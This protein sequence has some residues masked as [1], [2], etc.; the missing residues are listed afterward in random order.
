MN[1]NVRL[2]DAILEEAKILLRHAGRVY[3]IRWNRHYRVV[4]S[5]RGYEHARDEALVAEFRDYDFYTDEQRAENY[6]NDRRQY[7]EWYMGKRDYDLLRRMEEGVD[8]DPKTGTL[9]VPVGRIVDGDFV[10]TGEREAYSEG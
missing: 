1:R 2:P 3:V 5:L 4:E 9:S 8:F 7:P 10:W 6:I